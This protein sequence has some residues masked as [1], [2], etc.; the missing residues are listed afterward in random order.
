MAIASPRAATSRTGMKVD[1]WAARMV[2]A[3][4]RAARCTLLD[5]SK[6]ML[7]ANGIVVAAG[8]FDRGAALTAKTL[9][10]GGVAIAF[11]GDGGSS[12]CKVGLTLQSMNLAKAGP[13]FEDNEDAELPRRLVGSRRSGRALRPMHHR[14]GSDGHDLRRLGGRA[15]GGG[16]APGESERD[17]RQ[18]R[19]L[20]LVIRRADA[21]T[22][23]QVGQIDKYLKARRTA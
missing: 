12:N 10:T 4:G 20:L 19:P 23:R 8:L 18:A 2:G 22:Y 6:G 5:L 11:V 15:P 9:K 21:M 16:P 14:G 3:A 13:S 1:L 7:G 17:P